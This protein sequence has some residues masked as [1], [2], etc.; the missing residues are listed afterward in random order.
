MRQ[1]L[2]TSKLWLH[3]SN[4]AMRTTLAYT[5]T[6]STVTLSLLNPSTLLSPSPLRP[7]PAPPSPPPRSSPSA[8]PS[9]SPLPHRQPSH[10]RL[11]C[12]PLSALSLARPR[13]STLPGRCCRSRRLLLLPLQSPPP[14]HSRLAASKMLW[15][16]RW[17][18]EVTVAGRAR[19][20]VRCRALPPA[21]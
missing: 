15:T 19:G 8:L 11:G 13:S 1:S 16:M 18:M 5:N 10:S 7:L 17:A 2:P 12:L 20:R 9:H 3:S 21:Q 6:D 4:T 14:Y